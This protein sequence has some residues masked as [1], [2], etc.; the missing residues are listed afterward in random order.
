[1]SSYNSLRYRT[2]YLLHHLPEY[3]CALI[4]ILKKRFDLASSIANGPWG[5]KHDFY[6]MKDEVEESVNYL[7]NVF[8]YL[9]N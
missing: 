3:D 5:N 7:Y 6:Y 2:G 9:T 1:M 8:K 4:E